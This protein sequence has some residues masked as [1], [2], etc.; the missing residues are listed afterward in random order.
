MKKLVAVLALASIGA[1]AESM[2]G[3]IQCP[4][5]AAA[6]NSPVNA[7]ACEAGA[8]PVFVVGDKIYK[9]ANPGAVKGQIGNK[10]RVTGTIEGDTITIQKTTL[11]K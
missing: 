1:W 5:Q 11:P 6:K 9:I 2:S 10:I 8:A 3:T 7:P 4:K